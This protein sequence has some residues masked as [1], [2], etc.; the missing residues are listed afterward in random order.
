MRIEIKLREFCEVI[1]K[2]VHM[3]ELF[4]DSARTISIKL[5]LLLTKIKYE[6]FSVSAR[7]IK[8]K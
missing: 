8:M 7:I 1:N 3:R 4:S 5:F 2:I 6:S